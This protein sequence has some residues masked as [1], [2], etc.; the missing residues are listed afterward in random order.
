LVLVQV[1]WIV[2]VGGDFKPTGRFLMPI[3]PVLA[4]FA[5]V[6]VG[7]LLKSGW[8]RA[9]LLVIMLVSLSSV[10]WHWAEVEASALDRRA[11][12]EARRTLGLF[13]KAHL[14][15]DTVIAIHSAGVVPYFAELTTIDMWGLTDHHIARTPAGGFGQGIAGHEKSDPQYVFARNPQI[16]LP[17]DRVFTLKAWPLEVEPHFPAD[18]S[19]RYLA[20]SI[21]IEGR[22]ANIWVKRGFLASLNSPSGK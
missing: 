6:G 9:S 20:I 15:P 18:F 17:E 8:K 3:L 14:P 1:I 2:R 13:L 10:A 22:F 4:G 19:E 21:P 11:N 16:Y 7:Y 5:G 12:L